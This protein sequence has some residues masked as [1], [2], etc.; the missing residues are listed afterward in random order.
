[1]K[2]HVVLAVEE[3]NLTL[4]SVQLPAKGFCKLH[5][6]KSSTDNNYSGWLHFLAPEARVRRNPVFL[7]ADSTVAAMTE[8]AFRRSTSE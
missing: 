7:V 3:E 8:P 4:G 2:H 5:S 6:R 1:M